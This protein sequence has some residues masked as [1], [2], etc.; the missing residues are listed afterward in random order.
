MSHATPCGEKTVASELRER[1]ARA[2]RHR[3]CF[4]GSAV[5]LAEAEAANSARERAR[6]GSAEAKPPGSFREPS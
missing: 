5:A 6:K 1:A 3:R 4:G 2:A